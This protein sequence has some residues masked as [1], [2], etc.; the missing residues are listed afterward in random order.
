MSLTEEIH[1]IGIVPVIK[2][3][4]VSDAVPLAKALIDGNLPCAEVTF[5]TDAAAESIRLI[6]EA[7]PEMLIGAGTVLTIEQVDLAVKNGAQF[8]VSPGLNPVVVAYCVEKN[9]PIFPGVANASD[10]EQAL[11][12]GLEVVKFFPAETNGGLAAIN[13]LAGP[14]PNLKFI[15]TGGVNLDNM[16]AYLQSKKVVACGGTWMVKEDLINNGDFA[17]ITKIS[18]EAVDK[19]LGFE[20]AHVGINPNDEER[21]QGLDL[22]G[23]LFASEPQETSIS[24][25]VSD[26]IELMDASGK[27]KYGHIALRTHN[28]ERAWNYL[29]GKGFTFDASSIKMDGDQI[30]VVYLEQEIAGFAIHLLKG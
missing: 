29:E 14:Y 4:R 24:H 17:A 15:P 8:I 20:I 1:K 28:V 13:A 18:Q 25:F 26:K 27:G 30:K 3:D 16:G 6:S 12:L 19:M 9:I 10:I 21:A 2:I 23:K 11:Q 22:F 7:F 5:R